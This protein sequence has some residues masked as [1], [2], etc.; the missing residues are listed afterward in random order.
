MRRLRFSFTASLTNF[1]SS[2]PSFPSFST[3]YHHFFN[4]PL[5]SF[6][7]RPETGTTGGCISAIAIFDGFGG[8]KA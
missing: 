1:C 4:E 5:L 7:P 2:F 6:F 3:W 8:M